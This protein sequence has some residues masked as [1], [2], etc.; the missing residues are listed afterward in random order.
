M[1]QNTASTINKDSQIVSS[2]VTGSNT[3]ASSDRFDQISSKDNSAN[4]ILAALC[5]TTQFIQLIAF[6]LDVPLPTAIRFKDLCTSVSAI[7]LTNICNAAVRLDNS[8]IYIASSQGVPCDLL[9]R[10]HTLENLLTLLN[11]KNPRL[12][13]NQPFCPYSEMLLGVRQIRKPRSHSIL[14]KSSH[15]IITPLHPSVTH[16]IEGDETHLISC[17]SDND[18]DWEDLENDLAYSVYPYCNNNNI[19]S[20]MQQSG[21]MAESQE[22]QTSKSIF[23]ALSFLWRSADEK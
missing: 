21:T 12:G 19:N 13:H 15:P 3:T 18:S 23:G 8:I 9:L 16:V 2:N 7:N 10:G 22:H 4:G 6:I 17:E 20:E 11:T 5:Y 14:N 1:K